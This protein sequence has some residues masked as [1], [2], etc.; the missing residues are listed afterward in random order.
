MK[1]TLIVGVAALFLA[2]G[3]AH[4]DKWI[5]GRCLK[6]HPDDC[7]RGGAPAIEACAE[8]NQE[9]CALVKKRKSK[10]VR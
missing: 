4:A 2:T 3:T 7:I 1:K 10:K 9:A 5:H 6:T 8:G